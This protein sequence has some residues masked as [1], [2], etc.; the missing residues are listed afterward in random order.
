MKKRIQKKKFLGSNDTHKTS[1]VIFSNVNNVFTSLTLNDQIFPLTMKAALY[2]LF[3]VQSQREDGRGFERR[4][5]I[6]SFL[7]NQHGSISLPP[8]DFSM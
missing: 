8:A 7:E 5:S 4:F 2:L 1:K 3:V 6:V